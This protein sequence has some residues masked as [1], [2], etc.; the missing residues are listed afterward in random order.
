[1]VINTPQFKRWKE[2][3]EKRIKDIEGGKIWTM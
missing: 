3:V 1:M 2:D